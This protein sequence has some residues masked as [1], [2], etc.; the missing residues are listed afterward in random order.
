MVEVDLAAIAAQ[1]QEAVAEK[2]NLGHVHMSAESAQGSKKRVK[3]IT[4]GNNI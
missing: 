4:Y 1:D 2:R 3:F